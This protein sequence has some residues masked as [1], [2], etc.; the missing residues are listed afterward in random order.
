MAAIQKMIFA[1]LKFWYIKG[2]YLL[3]F[4]KIITPNDEEG[5]RDQNWP[6]A[7]LERW[8]QTNL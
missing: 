6:S 8:I 5:I 4:L 3:V 7:I 2:F 1:V